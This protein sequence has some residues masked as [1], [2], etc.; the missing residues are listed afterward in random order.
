M[1]F[2]VLLIVLLSIQNTSNESGLSSFSVVT[3]YL[4]LISQLLISSFHIMKVNSLNSKLTKDLFNT[5][6]QFDLSD[7][8]KR[9]FFTILRS[10]RNEMI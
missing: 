7:F 3:C 10:E 5:I 8:S 2:I 1:I 6:P 4:I 9:F